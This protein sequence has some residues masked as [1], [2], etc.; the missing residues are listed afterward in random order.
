MYRV[1]YNMAG[2]AFDEYFLHKY[3]DNRQ[4]AVNFAKD[5]QAVGFQTWIIKVK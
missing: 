5:R 1:N 4:A 3:F 2:F